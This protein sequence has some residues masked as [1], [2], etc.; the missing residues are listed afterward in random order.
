MINTTLPASSFH[1]SDHI[2]P[3]AN[4]LSLIFDGEDEINIITQNN[5]INSLSLDFNPYLQFDLQ[6]QIPILA[7]HPV[8]VCDQ[9]D[10]TNNFLNPSSL[11]MDP[12]AVSSSLSPENTNPCGIFTGDDLFDANY[13]IFMCQGPFPNPYE[14]QALSS[15]RQ[16]QPV[17]GGDMEPETFRVASKLTTEERKQKIHRY[18]KKRNQRNFSKKIKY[19]CRKTLA[20]SRP[21]VRG[22]FA[23]NDEL[24]GENNT[25]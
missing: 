11:F 10:D 1:S 2:I 13:G 7:Y 12:L 14:I 15:E 4:N 22:R 19:A 25:S 5:Q 21:R 8:E 6:N 17:N 23:K 3:P 9:D 18:L 16:R 20:D 24:F